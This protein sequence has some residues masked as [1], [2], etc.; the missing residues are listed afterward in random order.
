MGRDAGSVIVLD[1]PTVSPSHALIVRLGPGWLV[2]SLDPANPALI[3]D[4]TG[5]AQ[6]IEKELGLRSGELLIGGCR[7]LLYQPPA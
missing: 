4:H 2:S 7:V 1:D 6:P 5:R 3:L